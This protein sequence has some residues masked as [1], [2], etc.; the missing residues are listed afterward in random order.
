MR[1]FQSELLNVGECVGGADLS[2]GIGGDDHHRLPRASASDE[3][4]I[5]L[6]VLSGL[7]A[8]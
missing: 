2:V 3:F 7:F 8:L 1:Q 4:L 6:N 5:G